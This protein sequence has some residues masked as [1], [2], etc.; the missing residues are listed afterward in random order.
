MTGTRVSDLTKWGPNWNVTK[1]N[2]K[3]ND[4]RN[5][6]I[7]ANQSYLNSVIAYV[8]SKMGSTPLTPTP[9][10]APTPTATPTTTP[11]VTPS[12]A[13]TPSATPRTSP[14]PTPEPSQIGTV[15]PTTSPAPLPITPLPSET[16][17]TPTQPPI[18]PIPSFVPL[19]ACTGE[20]C[21]GV[22]YTS[23]EVYGRWHVFCCLANGTALCCDSG[24]TCTAIGCAYPIPTIT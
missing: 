18:T 14:T 24:T 10:P 1:S 21:N 7:E 19:R 12:P 13:A 6:T 16:P 4:G 22:C 11:I 20:W 17:I 8:A 2:C 9:T 15:I 23:C 3:T 5:V